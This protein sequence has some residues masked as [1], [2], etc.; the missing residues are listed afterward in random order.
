MSQP[1]PDTYVVDLRKFHDIVAT[2][3]TEDFPFPER[4]DDILREES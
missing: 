2:E 1:T 4:A 3:P